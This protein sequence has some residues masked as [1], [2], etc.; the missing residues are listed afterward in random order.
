M[1][2]TSP[3]AQTPSATLMRSSTGTPRRSGSTPDVLQAQ[4]LDARPAAGG[5]QQPVAAQ[6]LA[7]GE[8]EHVVVAVAARGGGMLAEVQLDALGGERL[9]ERLAQRLG[10]ARKDVIHALDQGDRR[11]H[12][13]DTA[14]AIS[15]PTGPPPS[16]SRRA[17]HLVQR[18]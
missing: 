4:S 15:T 2:V 3:I 17:R 12:A 16:T 13:R 6:L 8:L 11:A 7:V 10:L 14:W 5:H 9:A 1:P 18:R